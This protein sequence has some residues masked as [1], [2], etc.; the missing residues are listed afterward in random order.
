MPTPASSAIIYSVVVGS[1]RRHGIDPLL[2]L[3]DVLTRLPTMTNRDDLSALLP[4]KS[5]TSTPISI[6]SRCG[7]EIGS[8][9]SQSG[10]VNKGVRRSRFSPVS[11]SSIVAVALVAVATAHGK[12][13]ASTCEAPAATPTKFSRRCRPEP[14]SRRRENLV[15]NWQFGS[16]MAERWPAPGWP[17]KSWFFAPSLVCHRRSHTLMELPARFLPQRER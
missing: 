11:T 14:P 17:I 4:S 8:R 12:I 5:K 13:Y 2:Y 9:S 16:R 15:F 6:A 1:C 10:L 3:S 7:L